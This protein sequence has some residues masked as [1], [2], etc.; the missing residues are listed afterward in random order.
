MKNWNQS[1]WAQLRSLPNNKPLKPVGKPLNSYEATGAE[2]RSTF[3]THTDGLGFE[4]RETEA[5]DGCGYH[6]CSCKKAVS[7][8][9]PLRHN[10]KPIVTGLAALSL[11]RI[12]V[13]LRCV[14][15]IDGAPY[16]GVPLFYRLTDDEVECYRPGD[17]RVWEPSAYTVEAVCRFGFIVEAP[18]SA[19]AA[20]DGELD[21]HAAKVSMRAGKIVCLGIERWHYDPYSDL[22]Y[23]ESRGRKTAHPS[24]VFNVET[25]LIGTLNRYRVVE[26]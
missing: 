21:W 12:G 5:C 19:A 8:P 11:L 15:F 16:S 3:Y 23:A 25:P 6:V 2:N 1:A 7:E 4:Q 20:H 9:T 18:A 17:G 24:S 26:S 13:V 10:G 14:R 22:F